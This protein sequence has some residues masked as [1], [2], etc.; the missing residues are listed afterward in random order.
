[1]RGA[2]RRIEAR[3]GQLL[4]PAP[5]RGGKEMSAHAHSF[6]R[7]RRREFRLMAKAF[8]GGDSRFFITL[9]IRSIRLPES[10]REVTAGRLRLRGCPVGKTV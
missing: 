8:N 9:H 1:M 6:P 2:Q 4:G 10:V 3:I 5:K 7:E